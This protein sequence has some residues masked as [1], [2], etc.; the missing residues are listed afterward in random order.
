M[1]CC[2]TPIPV[3]RNDNDCSVIDDFL[4]VRNLKNP[5]KACPEPEDTCGGPSERELESEVLHLSVQIDNVRATITDMFKCHNLAYKR[6][7]QD[8]RALTRYYENTTT[9]IVERQRNND[10]LHN[11]LCCK[12]A[13]DFQTVEDIE[14]LMCDVAQI[15]ERNKITENKIREEQ[16]NNINASHNFYSAANRDAT[17]AHFLPNVNVVL[18]YAVPADT[19]SAPPGR[20][21]G[22]VLV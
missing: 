10:E 2:Q 21:A 1:D 18:R 15:E 22:S 3:D 5:T 16:V 14:R 11:T 6:L 13:A 8:F 7:A 17:L 19:R 20:A 4:E 9:M 12:T